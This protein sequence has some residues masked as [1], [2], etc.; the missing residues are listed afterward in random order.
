[1][2]GSKVREVVGIEI[3]TLKTEKVEVWVKGISPII[4]RAFAEKAW[5]E[6]LAPARKSRADRDQ[7]LK[8]EP[9]M[10]FRESMAKRKDDGPTRL[11]ISA[12]AFK[13]SIVDVAPR[14]PGVN[15]TELAQLV[16]V[17][18]MDL[19]IYGIPELY[20][21][22]VRSADMN[23]TPDVRT[24]G[25]LTDWCCK[26]TI[27]VVLPAL[28]GDKIMQLLTYAGQL[29]GVGDWR[30]QKGGNFGCFACV[31]EKDCASLMKTC[32]RAAQDKALETPRFFDEQSEEL[33]GWFYAE[34]GRRHD[35]D[36]L[37]AGKKAP[38]AEA[39][40]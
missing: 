7:N 16:W 12:G 33:F 4:P 39:A 26:L 14:L 18:G 15:K 23:R 24:R 31:S 5:R 38:K 3:P 19:D 11:V 37:K 27:K 2:R 25:V 22:M 35:G 34:M 29:I 20:M 32:G 13:R 1:M 10:E 17:E 21:T 30:R 40:G 8:H 36:K 6:L 28:N 9:L